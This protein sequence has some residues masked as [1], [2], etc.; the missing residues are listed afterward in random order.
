MVAK[1]FEYLQ[2]MM[3]HA[4][5]TKNND[6]TSY[7]LIGQDISDCCPYLKQSTNIYINKQILIRSAKQDAKILTNDAGEKLVNTSTTEV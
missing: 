5:D 4:Q 6:Y 7:M 2:M 1:K 3:V